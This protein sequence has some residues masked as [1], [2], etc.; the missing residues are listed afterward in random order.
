MTR[1]FTQLL[2][3]RAESNEKSRP[4]L[5]GRTRTL[6]EQENLLPKRF[7]CNTRDAFQ[8][9]GFLQGFNVPFLMAISFFLTNTIQIV[10]LHFEKA[11]RFI[12]AV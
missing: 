6:N 11:A 7:S 9:P 1:S 5:P 2:T 4:Q 12:S 10:Q 3:N 8:K